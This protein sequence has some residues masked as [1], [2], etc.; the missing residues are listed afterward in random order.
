MC[1]DGARAR[2][3]ANDRLRH[4]L[5]RLRSRLE[6]GRLPVAGPATRRAAGRG[7]RQR[8]TLRLTCRVRLRRLSAAFVVASDRCRRSE[9]PNP[10]IVSV[11][12]SPS[13]TLVAALGWSVSRRRA[14][15]CNSRRAGRAGGAAPPCA[16]PGRPHWAH[17]PPARHA[18]RVDAHTGVHRPPHDPPPTSPRRGSDF[19]LA[20]G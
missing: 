3:V 17:G 1:A 14:R 16:R 20:A 9:R 18:A 12:S 2:S 4:V 7:R 13:R 6:G 11:S 8:F 10:R 15:S 19:G 5:D